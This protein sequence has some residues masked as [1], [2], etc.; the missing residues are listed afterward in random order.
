M[1]FFCCSWRCSA[2][3]TPAVAQA[4]TTV[5]PTSVNF[6]NVVVGATSA[7]HTVNFKNTGATSISITSIA[8]TSGGPYALATAATS[9]CPSSGS[10]AAGASCNVGLTLTPTALG[11]QPADTL[12]IDST[13]TTGGTQTVAL[14]GTGVNPTALN[15]T[16]INFYGVEVGVTSSIHVV[17]LSNYET[18]S[19]TISSISVAAPYALDPSTTCANPG[20]LAAGGTCKIAVTLTPTVLGTVPASSLTVT[21]SAP[22]S[23]LTAM[24][25][26]AGETASVLAPTSI[27][28][29]GVA[30]GVTSA[31][32]TA[33]LYNYESSAINISSISVPSP[34]ALDPSTTCPSSGS[35]AAGGYCRINLTLTP[36]ALGAVPASSM[37][38]TT[39][40]P[41]SPLSTTLTG[42]GVVPTTL[43]ATSLAFGNVPLNTTS[44]IKTVTLHNAQAS[45]LS[46]ASITVPSPYALDPSTTCANPGTLA[47]GAEAAKLPVTLTPTA[48]GAVPASSLTITTNA[49]NSP[50]SVAL[51]GT[52]FT[53][54]ALSVTSI[55]FYGV[56]VGNTSAVHGLYL[57]NYESTPITISSISVPAPYALDPSTTC[58]NP[59][60]LAAGA[61][62][63]IEITLAPTALGAIPASS[64][65]VTTSAP[66]SPLTATLIGTGEA[67]SA[68]SSTSINFYGVVGRANHRHS[69]H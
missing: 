3:F 51:S 66:N 13:A 36:T 52:G 49:T 14:S 44:P 6:G 12:T 23:P 62:C 61:P 50:Q 65:T 43:S 39:S 5:S 33:T 24:L 35:L 15:S 2:S 37:T 10:L 22:N 7:M 56:A 63:K 38:V 60:T 47:A 29:Y 48:V 58:A 54:S 30:V 45:A 9:P 28:F 55:N 69:Y 57:V 46:I 11:T 18:S 26:G 25:S 19:I 17:V 68:L 64:L 59:G 40:A 4:Q 20:T 16:S 21:T 42:S 31:I 8:V 41:N 32:H 53:A 1:P 27:N 67:P 34:Y